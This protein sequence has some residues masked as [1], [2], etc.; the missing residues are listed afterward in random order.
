MSSSKTTSIFLVKSELCVHQ[1]RTFASKS[2]IADVVAIRRERLPACFR[3]PSRA[4]VVI[5]ERTVAGQDLSQVSSL[6]IFAFSPRT[7]SFRT[8][9]LATSGQRTSCISHSPSD[10]TR[11]TCKYENRL[12]AVKKAP[13]SDLMRGAGARDAPHR[14][15]EGRADPRPHV[16]SPRSRKRSQVSARDPYL[17]ST[18][19][20]LATF[21]YRSIFLGI[22]KIH[23]WRRRNSI[24]L[25]GWFS[26]V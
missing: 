24:Q 23:T 17:F 7:F 4:V 16:L 13:K 11:P 8:R 20:I 19:S 22:S 3:R 21:L 26:V 10:Q 18:R 6:F 1:K 15:L 12:S 25:R 9:P 2:Q 14:R 5:V